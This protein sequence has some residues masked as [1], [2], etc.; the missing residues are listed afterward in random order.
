MV[1]MWVENWADVMEREW[2]AWLAVVLVIS[3]VIPKAS[4]KVDDSVAGRVV[5]KVG[6]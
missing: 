3:K 4:R 2:V 6:V 5:W 1:G